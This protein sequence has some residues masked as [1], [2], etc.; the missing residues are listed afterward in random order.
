M[1]IN[2]HQHKHETNKQMRILN[3]F[4]GK[5]QSQ[6]K[7][8]T[9]NNVTNKALQCTLKSMQYF[10]IGDQMAVK[11]FMALHT[12][13]LVMCITEH[14]HHIT[15]LHKTGSFL[16]ECAKIFFGD[17]LW[18]IPRRSLKCWFL[19]QHWHSCLPEKNL[20]HHITHIYNMDI[21]Y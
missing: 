7:N 14:K 12:E 10:A 19:V 1:T 16:G 21:R 13:K 11:Y 6:L 15:V 5:M 18:W 2:I 4:I 3:Q 8:Y 17:Q 20:A 9:W